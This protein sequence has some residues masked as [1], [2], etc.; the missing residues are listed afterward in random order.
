MTDEDIVDVLSLLKDRDACTRTAM[1]NVLAAEPSGEPSLWT[2]IMKLLDDDSPAVLQI[3][4]VIGEVR[5]AAAQALSQERRAFEAR[6]RHA[7][8]VLPS[9]RGLDE[10]IAV[11]V[12]IPITDGALT[13]LAIDN[14][15]QSQGFGN[16]R[17]LHAFAVLRERGLIERTDIAIPPVDR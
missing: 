8:D 7:G 3:P 13:R 5:W 15:V 6:E 16:E 1:L 9:N 2:A 12:T 10:P 11:N 14:H 4:L 17:Q